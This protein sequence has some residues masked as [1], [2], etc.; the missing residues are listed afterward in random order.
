MIVLKNL[1]PEQYESRL[2]ALDSLSQQ[3]RFKNPSGDQLYTA[4]IYAQLLYS[5][6]AEDLS[7]EHKEMVRQNIEDN[8]NKITDLNL[9]ST[10][11]D[12]I[13]TV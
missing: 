9:R 11:S 2:I 10:I 4:Q 6:Y 5:L 3:N 8:F 1:T 12:L 13:F 7:D